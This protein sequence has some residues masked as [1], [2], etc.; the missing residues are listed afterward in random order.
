VPLITASILSKKLA[1]GL[2]GLVMD[3]KTGSGAFLPSVEA[4]RELGRSIVD[5]ATGAG[6]PTVALLT[7]MNE[8]LGGT[9]GNALEVGEAV[10]LL[11]G[12]GGDARLREVTLALAREMLALGGLDPA[13]AEPALASGAAAE[14]FERMVAALGGPKDIL[15]RPLDAAPV[16]REA[17]PARGGV[18]AAIDVRAVGLAVVE[19]GGGRTRADQAIDHRVGLSRVAGLG[20]SV[21]PGR[22]LARIHARDDAAALRAAERLARAFTIGDAPPA[23]PPLVVERLA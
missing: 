2:G 15:T 11:A 7:D 6:L 23:R 1:A 8:V 10:D 5:V 21:G 20:A 3:V 18:V 19:L 22:P 17:P 9:A 4:A 13:R 12:R 16:V 14:R